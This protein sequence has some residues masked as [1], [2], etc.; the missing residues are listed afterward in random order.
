MTRLLDSD[1]LRHVDRQI[2]HGA[3]LG[4]QR[5]AVDDADAV[6]P[7]ALHGQ[8]LV[9]RHGA[10]QRHLGSAPDQPGYEARRVAA[11]PAVERAVEPRGNRDGLVHGADYFMRGL[12][13][14]G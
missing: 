6:T 4:D 14:L 13:L 8:R 7:V 12:G 1:G 9:D 11:L 2:R 3:A 10:A 5:L